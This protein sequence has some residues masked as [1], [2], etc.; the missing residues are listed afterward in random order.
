V[1]TG[2]GTYSQFLHVL[3]DSLDDAFNE[4]AF[5]QQLEIQTNCWRGLLGTEAGELSA[6]AQGH[7]LAKFW[8]ITSARLKTQSQSYLASIG[9]SDGSYFLIAELE[10]RNWRQDCVLRE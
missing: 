8:L 4:L 9:V 10:W 6:Q 2:D 3:K 1:T 7:P 5:R